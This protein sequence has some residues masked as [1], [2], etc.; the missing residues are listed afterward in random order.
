MGEQVG[1]DLNHFPHLKKFIYCRMGDV[2]QK[3]ISS[4]MEFSEAEYQVL[5]R[6]A[7][8]RNFD[9][10]VHIIY[11][12]ETETYI[13]II[14]KGLVRKY[15]LKG[16]EEVVTKIAREGNLV[17]ASDSFLTGQP[18]HYWIETLEPTTVISFSKESLESIYSEGKQ[19]EKLGRL[20]MTKLLVD[21]ESWELEFATLN[22]QGR[23]MK[24]V[25]ENPHLV[26]RVPQKYLASYL[27][28]Q[29]ETFSRL[30]SSLKL[31]L[32]RI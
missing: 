30:K 22:I 15:F 10:K 32:E 19:F 17:S 6:Y 28:I 4:L 16:E 23:F 18:T 31:S 2:I 25:E 21:R 20:I 11:A 14:R 7:L 8:V 9:R 5:N 1:Y 29:P 12:G 3:Y 24:F 13:N 27:N 26:S